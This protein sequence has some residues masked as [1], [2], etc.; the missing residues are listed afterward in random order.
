MN[1]GDLVDD[2]YAAAVT[3]ERWGRVLDQ[4]A[5]ISDAEGTILFTAGPE[6]IRWV[7]TGAICAL[8]KEWVSSEWLRR[9]ERGKRLIPRQE[10]RFL[11]DLDGFTED[12]LNREP[13]YTEFLRPRGLGWCA[14]TAIALPSGRP[15][16]FSIEKAYSKGPVRPE[17]IEVL[18]G[19]RPHLVRSVALATEA[20]SSRVSMIAEALQ[21][22]GVAAAIL[23][24][25]GS[26]VAA[27]PAFTE[28]G[29]ALAQGYDDHV[30]FS[31]PSAQ[32]AF[33]QALVDIST[34]RQPRETRPIFVS[35]RDP[36]GALLAHV[37]PLNALHR[38]V[39]LGSSSLL[40]AA[41]FS[42]RA[43]NEHLLMRLFNL[44]PTEAKVVSLLVQGES[45]Q[46]I[47][48]SQRVTPN[49]IRIQLKS[50]FNKTGVHRQAQL[51]SLLSRVSI[52]ISRGRRLDA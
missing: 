34:N 1:I 35:A 49:T 5:N 46:A 50:V 7:S 37:L 12:E 24:R 40:L 38:D 18:D 22:A 44:T 3:P 13:F 39:F 33:R 4:M 19:L 45:V 25:D 15:I 31:S 26:V 2:I 42:A 41:R 17:A 20:A 36:G 23:R 8:V 30:I 6:G 51:V 11:T 14:G 21:S 28:C 27:N 29:A 32:A 48:R 9:N 10:P 16:V 52:D 43:P 47:A